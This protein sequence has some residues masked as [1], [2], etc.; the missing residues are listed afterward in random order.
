MKAFPRDLGWVTKVE[1]SKSPSK[2]REYF[3]SNESEI[4]FRLE[5]KWRYDEDD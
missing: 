2:D 4:G 3:W 5:Q 1:N